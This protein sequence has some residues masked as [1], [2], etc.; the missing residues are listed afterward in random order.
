MQLHLFGIGIRL[1]ATGQFHQLPQALVPDNFVIVRSQHFTLNDHRF[2]LEWHH[3]MVALPDPYPLQIQI[4]TQKETIQID[5]IDSAIAAM[6]LDV[7]QGTAGAHTPRVVD[8]VDHIGD[9]GAHPISARFTDFAQHENGLITQ[10]AQSN[11]HEGGT[12]GRIDRIDERRVDHGK[13]LDDLR[14]QF[15]QTDP[16]CLDTP[17]PAWQIDNPLFADHQIQGLR[18]LSPNGDDNFITRADDVIVVNR[19]IGD[20]RCPGTKNVIAKAPNDTLHVRYCGAPSLIFDR[21]GQVRRGSLTPD[22]PTRIGIVPKAIAFGGVIICVWPSA[23]LSGIRTRV[24]S[25]RWPGRSLIG[26]AWR[27]G[28]ISRRLR[29]SGSRVGTG[30]L[31]ISRTRQTDEQQQNRNRQPPDKT[32]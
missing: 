18:H 29:G 10:F 31:I 9:T 11:I 15:G 25:G 1:E 4:T 24:P 21:R 7:P 12:L 6:N 22:S 13:G 8:Q 17:A 19:P 26:S 16:V 3:D 14:L 23:R 32:E 20:Q 2:T 28:S 27:Y 5:A 30:W